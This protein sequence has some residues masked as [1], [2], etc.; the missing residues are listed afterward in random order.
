MAANTKY[1]NSV[2]SWGARGCQS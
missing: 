1:K 2:F